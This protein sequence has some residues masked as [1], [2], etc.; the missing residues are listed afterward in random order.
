MRKRESSQSL[1][2]RNG[3][4]EKEEVGMIVAENGRNLIMVEALN[5]TKVDRG[6]TRGNLVDT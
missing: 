1:L 4:V 3:D 5:D 2:Y 6:E